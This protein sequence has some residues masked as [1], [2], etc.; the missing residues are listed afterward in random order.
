M[1]IKIVMGGPDSADELAEAS[2]GRTP[3]QQLER[4]N[5]R[6]GEDQGA[7]KER[8]RLNLQ[9]QKTSRQNG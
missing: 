5:D 3:Q 8:A 1:G 4:L 2:S 6:L 9:I 7:R